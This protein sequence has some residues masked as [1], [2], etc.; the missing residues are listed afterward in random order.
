MATSV[1]GGVTCAVCRHGEVG[2][3]KVYRFSLPI[4]VIGWLIIGSTLFMTAGWIAVM[5]RALTM[6]DEIAGPALFW[7]LVFAVCFAVMSFIFGLLG[8]FCVLKRK[9]ILCTGCRH[10]LG[11]AA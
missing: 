8:Y 9:V 7:A 5:I 2:I 6:T 10:V 4:V 11:D 3:A 1:L